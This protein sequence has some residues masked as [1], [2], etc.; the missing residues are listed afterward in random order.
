MHVPNFNDLREMN[1]ENP[2]GRSCAMGVHPNP[3]FYKYYWWVFWA[4]SPIDGFA[5]FDDS[6]RLNTAAAID[7][8]DELSAKGE[9]YLLYNRRVPRRDP[10]N[11][12]DLQS[13]RW[14]DAK[15]AL[16][17]DED[18]DPIASTPLAGHR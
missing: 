13:P 11:P 12:F 16:S 8:M 2:V 6:N 1:A 9:G 7:L 5:F 4:Q 3:R 14:H 17:Y 15:W 18:P 10:A